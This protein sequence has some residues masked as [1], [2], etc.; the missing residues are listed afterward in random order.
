MDI[1]YGSQSQSQSASERFGSN[2]GSGFDYED[3]DE[4]EDDYTSGDSSYE[5]D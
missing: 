2:V 4:E 3:D 5:E 1:D